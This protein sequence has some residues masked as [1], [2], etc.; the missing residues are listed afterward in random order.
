MIREAGVDGDDD[1]QMTE[2]LSLVPLLVAW[3][4]SYVFFSAL[5]RGPKPPRCLLVWFLARS[6]ILK[7]EKVSDHANGQ[8]QY[9]PPV[10]ARPEVS[11]Q[12]IGPQQHRGRGRANVQ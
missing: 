1:R 2:R 3:R 4:A 10:P 5:A 8:L 9:T 11:R 6:P 7:S 12:P